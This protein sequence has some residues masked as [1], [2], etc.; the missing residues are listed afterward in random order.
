ML[1][2][3][4]FACT[5]PTED[6]AASEHYDAPDSAGSFTAVS[7]QST[8]TARGGETLPVQ[9]W[10]PSREGDLGDVVEYDGIWTDQARSQGEAACGVPR[11]VILFSHGNGG[12]R[13][14]STFF[15]E[16][17]AAH[18]YIVVA[19]DHVGNTLTD[20]GDVD[21]DTVAL[22][23]PHDIQDAYE[24]LLSESSTVGSRLYGCAQESDGYAVVG[25][26]FGG[27]TSLFLSGAQIDTAALSS[28]C[29]TDGG[30]WLCGIPE[31]A[32][33][34]V[35]S[36]KDERIWAAVPMTPVGAQTFGAQL[37]AQDTPILVLGG[38]LDDLTT[39][40]QQVT[41]IYEGVGG[42]PAYL[43]T[44]EG[45]GHYSFSVM[46]SLVPSFNGCGEGFLDHETTIRVTNELTLGFLGEQRGYEA[47]AFLP[48][49]GP[50][51]WTAR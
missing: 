14:Q 37:S 36:R 13:W 18:G 39:M 10:Y 45:A 33:E 44:L 35:V 24:W 25:H 3:L 26:S 28:A 1:L 21:R 48:T 40:A 30:G 12:V 51:E 32:Q 6:T 46:C 34:A 11:P 41:P 43:A 31:I 5:A 29:E 16:M 50:V 19:P 7:Y 23:R 20:I 15:T 9:V 17:A 42:S 38:E 2:P 49:E 4:L 47:S 22:R 8:V 27:F